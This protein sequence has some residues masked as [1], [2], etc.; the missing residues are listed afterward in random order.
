[1]HAKAKPTSY[2]CCKIEL[3]GLNS[4]CRK[5]QSL[6]N[7]CQHR[8]EMQR[9]VHYGPRCPMFL[10]FKGSSRPEVAGG[11]AKPHK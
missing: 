5:C 2:V 7:S 11:N 1:M 8:A 3:G 9:G 6:L 10:A 4:L